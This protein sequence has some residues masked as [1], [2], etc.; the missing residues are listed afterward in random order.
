[1]AETKWSR[2]IA[3]WQ[4]KDVAGRIDELHRDCKLWEP[5]WIVIMG[6]GVAMMCATDTQRTIAFG[7]LL[8]VVGVVNMGIRK[9]WVHTELSILHVVKE[10]QEQKAE[11][12]G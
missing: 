3:K 12:P 11:I 1:M 10:L 2:M 6:A 8:A 7:L 5:V 9:A 4:D